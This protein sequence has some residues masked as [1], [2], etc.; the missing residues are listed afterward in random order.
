MEQALSREFAL[1]GIEDFF[2]A[3]SFTFRKITAGMGWKPF[4]SVQDEG[5]YSACG[6]PE[7]LASRTG[8]H[9]EVDE[10]M[11]DAP[12]REFSLSDTHNFFEAENVAFR[13]TSAGMGWKHAFM[14]V[15]DEGPYTKY[16][17]SRGDL[18]INVVNRGTVKARIFAPGREHGIEGGPG[19]VTIIPDSVDFKLVLDCDLSTTRLY[20]RRSLLERVASRIHGEEARRVEVPFYAAVYDPVIEQLCHAV[21]QALEEGDRTSTCYV[22]HFVEAIAAHIVHRYSTLGDGGTEIGKGLTDR[23]LRRT[24]EF[25][26]ARIG[27]RLTLADI[28]AEFGFSADHF[29]RLFKQSAGLTL[30]QFIIRCRVD[31]ARTLLAET[32]MPIIEIAQE[33]GFADQVHLTRAMRRI[34]GTTPAAFRRKHQKIVTDS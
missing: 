5:G 22:E 14:S 21:R 18:L 31:R 34:A 9:E 1:A 6:G 32:R 16:F 7:K 15:Q 24:R 23:Q 30:Y 26:E 20:L 17:P 28:A 27:E 19:T 2:G 13:K 33:C 4:M 25:I 10:P 11:E 12:V 3:E 8:P 29:G